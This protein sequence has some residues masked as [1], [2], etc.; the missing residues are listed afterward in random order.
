[1]FSECIGV[2]HCGGEPVI[3]GTRDQQSV[4]DGK[5]CV[6]PSAAPPAWWRKNRRFSKLHD[7]RAITG[8]NCLN[9][10]NLRKHIPVQYIPSRLRGQWSISE[11]F[12]PICV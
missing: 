3:R 7:D 1:M 4:L 9:Q 6:I 10:V 2:A 11:G 12:C 8:V 5:P